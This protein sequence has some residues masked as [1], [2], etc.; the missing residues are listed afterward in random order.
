MMLF[1]KVVEEFLKYMEEKDSSKQTIDNYGKDL[2]YLNTF[3]EKNIT[4]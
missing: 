2:R 3:L 4:E 1:V